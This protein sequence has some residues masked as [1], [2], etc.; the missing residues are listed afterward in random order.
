MEFQPIMRAL[1][2]NRTGAVLVALQIALALAV[3]V[4]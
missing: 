4:N 1:W 3:V 2:R